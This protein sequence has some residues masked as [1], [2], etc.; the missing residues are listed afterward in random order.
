MGEEESYRRVVP[1][2]EQEEQQQTGRTISRY[3]NPPTLCELRMKESSGG[4][5]E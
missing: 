4:G 2:S 1:A 3:P 5:I